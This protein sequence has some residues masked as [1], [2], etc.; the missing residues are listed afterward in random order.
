MLFVGQKRGRL[1]LIIHYLNFQVVISVYRKG[2]ERVLDHQ[3][4]ALFWD[5]CN[6]SRLGT[7][8]KT[9]LKLCL[10]YG[11]RIAELRLAKKGDFDLKLGVWTVP[12]ENHKTGMKT[13]KA[14]IR[15]IIPEIY[16]LLEA[17]IN[18]RVVI[19]SFRAGRS[20]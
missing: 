12:A 8:N 6:H 10:F 16:P 14:L 9:L 5:A 7:R 18:F 2:W 11:C 3:E 15:P 4:I 17:V 1:F 19:I 13:K 20:L